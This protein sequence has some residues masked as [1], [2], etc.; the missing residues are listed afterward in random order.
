MSASTMACMAEALGIAMPGNAAIPASD[1]RR[2]ALAH[3][4]GHAIVTMTKNDVR[5]SQIVKRNSFENAIRVLAAIGGS[6]NAIVHL[7]AL[8]GRLKIPLDLDDFQKYGRH[9]PLL[10][11]LKP[12]GSFLMEGSYIYS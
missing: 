11:N 1:S 9:I 3:M 2:Y 12:S 4:A 6:T 7:L 10:V 5:F 8:A